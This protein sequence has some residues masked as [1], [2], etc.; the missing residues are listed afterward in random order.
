ML[1]QAPVPLAPAPVFAPLDERLANLFTPQQR[2]QLQLQMTQVNYFH[3]LVS[4]RENYEEKNNSK[5]KQK[6]IN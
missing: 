2:T 3:L 1:P 6:I 4:K 5:K